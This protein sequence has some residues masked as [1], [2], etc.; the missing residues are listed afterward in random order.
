MENL[1]QFKG[2]IGIEY[3]VIELSSELVSLGCE[4]ICEFGNWEEILNDGNVVVAT[5][6]EGENHIQIFFKVTILADVIEEKIEASYIEI[7][8]VIEF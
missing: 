1:E 2:L 6:E 4:D 3:S 8:D 5:D 7:S